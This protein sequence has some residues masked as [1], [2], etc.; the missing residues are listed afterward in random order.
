M[1]SPVV[2]AAP[3]QRRNEKDSAEVTIWHL[4]DYLLRPILANNN[5][6]T[7]AASNATT[8]MTTCP[9]LPQ[10][11]M[12][13]RHELHSAVLPADGRVIPK[14]KSTGFTTAYFARGYAQSAHPYW[15]QCLYCQ[16]IFSSRYYLDV[17]QAAMHHE[18]TTSTTTTNTAM[19]LS[20]ASHHHNTTTNNIDETDNGTLHMICPATDWCAFLSPTACHLRALADEPYYGRGSAGRRPDRYRIEAA[21]W[22][23]AHATPCTAA[24]AQQAQRTCRAVGQACFGG[25]DHDDNDKD[26]IVQRM[27]TYW[28]THVCDAAALSCPN[29]LQQLYFRTQQDGDLVFRQVHE[30]QDEWRYWSEEHFVLGWMGIL[31]VVVLS[32]FYCRKTWQHWQKVRHYHRAGP[33]LLRPKK[34][35]R[36]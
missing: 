12:G 7:A 1:A 36:L 33:R 25:H 24:A 6:T 35:K 5:A 22:K 27:A 15:Y 3:I 30:W 16:K 32:F 19:S 28:Q 31:L 29:R 18:N 17:H 23:Q 14:Q 4:L 9:L 20:A 21:L 13:R 26:S 11:D 8:I 34:T 10:Y 2:T